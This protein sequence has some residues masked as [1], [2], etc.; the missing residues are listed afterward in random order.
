MLNLNQSCVN[1]AYDGA[2]YCW[3][4]H[5]MSVIVRNGHSLDQ[6]LGLHPYHYDVHDDDGDGGHDDRGCDG[7][8]DDGDD[9]ILEDVL[10]AD[11]VV[12][13]VNS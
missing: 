2:C 6:S 5:D 1:F 9:E 11:E 12:V 10:V 3:S 8:D 7:H 4:C 13:E